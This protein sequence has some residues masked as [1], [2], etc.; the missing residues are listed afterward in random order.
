MVD[1]LREGRSGSVTIGTF[2]S[3]AQSWLPHVAHGLQRDFPDVILELS[4]DELGT[5]GQAQ[6]SRRDIEVVNE[7]ADAPGIDRPGYSRLVLA[8]EGYCLVAPAGH[9][10]LERYAGPIPMAALA[11]VPMVDN[12]FH[13]TGCSRIIG[14]A[15]DAAG[16]SPRFVARSDDHHTALAFVAG[17]IGVTMLPDLAVPEAMPGVESRVAGQPHAPSPDRRP[18]ARR[19]SLGPARRPCGRA[20]PGGRGARPLPGG[21][22]AEG[23]DGLDHRPRTAKSERKPSPDTA[24]RVQHVDAGRVGPRSTNGAG[25]VPQGRARRHVRPRSGAET[26][27]VGARGP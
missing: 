14:N 7:A 6:P 27:G 20:P 26:V 17:G 3:A 10:L 13:H 8:E 21:R 22:R 2:D 11:D 4:L 19:R 25:P 16:F 1:Q 5:A 12:D 15:C 24:A 23:V 18:R 9:E